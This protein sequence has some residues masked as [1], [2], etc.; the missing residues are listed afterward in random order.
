MKKMKEKKEENG[1]ND[2]MKHRLHHVIG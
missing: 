2:L 1:G